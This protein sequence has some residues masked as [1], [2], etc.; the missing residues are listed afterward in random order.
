MSKSMKRPVKVV[1]DLS[2]FEKARLD[3]L[4]ERLELTKQACVRQLIKEAAARYGVL[5][6]PIH[7]T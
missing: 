4:A 5:Q 3:A 1:T 6:D 7:V 2:P